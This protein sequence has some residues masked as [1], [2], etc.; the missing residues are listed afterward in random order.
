MVAL[1]TSLGDDARAESDLVLDWSGPAECPSRSDVE[2][3]VRRTLGASNRP[4]KKISVE[5]RASRRRQGYRV[6]LH[7]RVAETDG[8]R[9]LDGDTCTEVADAAALV[10][11]LAI[12]PDALAPPP[13]P[14]L[15]PLRP[16]PPATPPA[17]PAPS[18]SPREAP[19]PWF[20]GAGVGATMGSV[21]SPAT[22]FVAR[23]GWTDGR[24]RLVAYATTS[25]ETERVIAPDVGGSFAATTFGVRGCGGILRAGALALWGCAGIELDR[26]TGRGFGV[27]RPG[28]AVGT[29]AAP[30]L[31]VLPTWNVSRHLAVLLEGAVATP[32]S[33]PRFRLDDVGEVFR[34]GGLTAQ[35]DVAVELRFP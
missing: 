18:P 12:D 20:V 11:A 23:V 27:D 4:R 25:L 13:E 17:R 32:L 35:V 30:T 19:A 31:A 21:P 15:P 5:G 16:S 3:Q 28:R 24:V 34:P 6:T 14:A 33:R 1:V 8:E 10:I 7:T 22:S 2:A 26:V 29:W 9:I